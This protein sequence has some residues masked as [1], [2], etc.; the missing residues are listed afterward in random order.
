[1]PA[2]PYTAESSY[3]DS[4]VKLDPKSLVGLAKGVNANLV[5]RY[6][7]NMNEHTKNNKII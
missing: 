7:S 1:M 6:K 2:H 5:Y 4:I 3:A